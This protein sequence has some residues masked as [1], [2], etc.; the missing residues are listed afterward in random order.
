MNNYMNYI[1]THIFYFSLSISF[2]YTIKDIVCFTKFM[3]RFKYSSS[4]MLHI[5][6]TLDTVSYFVTNFYQEN[7][8]TDG[9]YSNHRSKPI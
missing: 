3:E 7:I 8:K 9:L 5:H 2:H 6:R 1:H 4:S